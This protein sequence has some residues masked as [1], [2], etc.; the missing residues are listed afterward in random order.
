LSTLGVESKSNV[1]IFAENRV[2]WVLTIDAS[3]L[4]GFT[5]VALYDTFTVDALEFSV[6]NCAAKYIIVSGKNIPAFLKMSD[7]AIQQFSTIILLDV[8]PA[9]DSDPRRRFT[10]LGS[11]IVTFDDIVTRGKTL[12]LPFA[13]IDPEQL[14]YICYSSGTTGFPKGVMISHRCFVT[15][16]LAV[17]RERLEGSFECHL[18][19][20]PLCHV[21][22]RMCTSCILIHGG[23]VGIYSGDL[24]LLTQDFAA[25]KPSV[26]I[27]VP[28][29]L[30]RIQ[31][32]ISAQVNSSWF[33][34]TLFNTAWSIKK[35]LLGHEVSPAVVDAVVFNKIKR[36]FGG[37]VTMIVNGGAAL[38]A[39]LHESLQ[40]TL[41][42][43]IRSG[44]GLSEGGSGNILNPGKLQLIKYGTVGYPLANIEIK[45]DPVPDFTEPGVGE[46]LMGGTG[47]CSG[48]LHDEEA[49]AALFTDESHTWIHTGDIGK[50]DE[51][52]S[53]VIVDRM[54]S[55]FKLSQGEYVA[56][57]LIASFFEAGALIE[58]CYV[59]GD[60][61][62]SFLVAVVAPNRAG[63][64]AWLGKRQIS[65]EEFTAQVKTPALKEA[66]VKQIK[67]ISD[68]KKLLGYQ[69]VQAV[70]L[71]EDTWTIEN[72][73]LSPTFKP[74]RKVLADRYRQQIEALYASKQ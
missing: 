51:D 53:C 34:R 4:Y 47:L 74:K 35:F 68:A 40:V 2:E 19:Y 62:R 6:N 43:P 31:D 37:R 67:E 30:Q 73:V 7:S 17:Y 65:D 20:L 18:C 5:L 33:K 1:C 63:V 70:A 24:K 9:E 44:Y 11:N 29:V 36:M 56:G 41:G 22:E 42:W 3:Y 52:N 69:R 61:T 58:H 8:L 16:L 71:V 54:R 15:N 49:T 10:A 50:F 21:F 45:I 72:G 60:A 25:L 26:V 14:A 48:Y 64:E 32:S 28:R 57:D 55:I 39:D 27:T 38:A 66:I 46:I 23:R 12:D 13:T 59:H